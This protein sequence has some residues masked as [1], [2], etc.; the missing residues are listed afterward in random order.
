[1][2]QYGLVSSSSKNTWAFDPRIVGSCVLWLDGADINT[3]FQNT[4]GTTPVTSNGQTVNYWTDKSGQGNN[5]ISLTSGANNISGNPVYSSSPTGVT[6]TSASS[7]S[8]K[9][10]YNSLSSSS[11]IGSGFVV[12]VDS[13]LSPSYA[14]T[15]I[16]GTAS[17][18]SSATGGR[19][20]RISAGAMQMNNG[21]ITGGQ[22]AT[23]NAF[24]S[25][26]GLIN[27]IDTGATPLSYYEF[28]TQLTTAGTYNGTYTASRITTVGCRGGGTGYAE[29]LNGTVLELLVFNS[30]LGIQARQQIEGYL[31]WKWG[32]Q[33]NLPATHPFKSSTGS[34][35]KPFARQFSPT[36]I[37]NCVLWFDGSDLS[38]MFQDT[39]GT[40]PISATGQSVKLWKDKAGFGISASN[41]TSPPTV[42]FSAQNNRSVV[43]F[44]SASS[45]SLTLSS[46]SSLPTGAITITLFIVS[47]DASSTGSGGVFQYGST[48]AN[49]T[50]GTGLQVLYNNAPTLIFIDQYGGNG[51]IPSAGTVNTYV[52][53]T[54][55]IGTGASNAVGWRNSTLYSDQNNV[56]WTMNIPSGY[57]GYIGTYQDYTT[58]R[59]LNG[60]IAEIIFYNTNFT[61]SQRQQVE[62]YLAWK[63]GLLTSIGSTHPFYKVP[64]NATTPFNPLY[65]SGLVL[66]LDAADSSTITQSGGSVS[67]WNDKSGNS[68]NAVQASSSIQPTYANSA[69]TFNGSSQYMTLSSASTL[70]NGA[71]PTGT[72]FFV[73]KL[74]TSSAVQ[75][76]FMYGPTTLATGANHQFYYNASNQLVIDTFGAGGTTDSTNVYN[77][78]VILSSTISNS[79]GTGTVTGWRNS[80]SFGPTTYT[81]ASITSQKGFVGVTQTGVGTSGTLAY[82]FGGNIYEILIYNSVLS[83]PRRQQVEGY[84]A[85]KWGLQTSLPSTHA[86]YKISP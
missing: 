16:G 34:I 9:G 10:M 22:T 27:F 20:W 62:G 12:L 49:Y 42:T 80:N 55:I 35:V 61:T 1:M 84:L 82:Y 85:W 21:G 31:A 86:Y 29:F 44:A 65:L 66:W 57:G 60:N 70:P 69:V 5:T 28:G 32:L 26:T 59:P 2:S 77:T 8:G 53:S 52:I 76:F 67:Q 74:T 19:Q 14:S 48:S 72:Y 78:S 17:G 56:T 24:S 58:F 50:P 3:L 23:L 6:F 39:A 4:A 36:D 37:P 30:A 46:T 33:A 43:S 7:T 38:T 25:N 71:T 54:L 51:V 47:L 40:T 81:T 11:A 83:G 41:N 73:T 75:A 79:G 18:P 64:T 45:Q 13:N 15:I 68:D 63:W